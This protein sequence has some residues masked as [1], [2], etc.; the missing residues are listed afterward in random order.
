VNPFWLSHEEKQPWLELSMGGGHGWSWSFKGGAM[1]E[2]TGEGREGEGVGQGV[3]GGRVGYRRE[4]R[5]LLLCPCY[6]CALAVGGRRRE[7]KR[8][9][10]KEVKE[11]EREKGKIFQTWKFPKK[12]KYNL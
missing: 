2:L 12:I 9:K 10:R 8:E 11:K 5:W 4:A 1:G 6:W 7:E 3:L